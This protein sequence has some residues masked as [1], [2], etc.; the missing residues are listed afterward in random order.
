MEIG[1][2]GIGSISLEKFAELARD[3]NFMNDDDITNIEAE[4]KAAKSNTRG[5]GRRRKED[6]TSASSDSM[7]NGHVTLDDLLTV[8]R[9]R[10]EETEKRFNVCS[11]CNVA[12]RLCES[13]SYECPSCGGIYRA[14][15]ESCQEIMNFE[16]IDQKSGGGR[17]HGNSS[18]GNVDYSK[19]QREMIRT[20]LTA[21]FDKYYPNISEVEGEKSED[22]LQKAVTS[23]SSAED[24][25][26]TND[27]VLTASSGEGANIVNIGAEDKSGEKLIKNFDGVRIPRS[28]IPIIVDRYMDIIK[29]ELDEISADGTY[30]GKKKFVKRGNVKK[31]ILGALIYYECLGKR[32]PFKKKEIA[33]LL[34]LPKE[35]IAHGEEILRSLAAESKINLPRADNVVN[36]YIDRYFKAFE[37]EVDA[38]H[39]LRSENC[40]GCVREIVGAA[41]KN[42]VGINMIDTTRITGTIWMLTTVVEGQEISYTL[43]EK[44]CRGVKKN[45][46]QRFSKD[47]I[48]RFDK[49][50]PIIEKWGFKLQK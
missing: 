11:N 18:G 30:V 15:E 23:S 35:G 6:K 2:K 29:L 40:K 22:I 27:N 34:F 7:S 31:E 8:S 5:R 42:G 38:D 32:I 36:D 26:W 37:T 50:R 46:F 24:D 28:I 4:V 25:I 14:G 9:R 13:Y 49:F 19:T 48:A 16:S 10:A 39:I 43:L 45:T 21:C 17:R 12:M 44:S 47:L 3:E 41:R 33:A 1:S 20:F